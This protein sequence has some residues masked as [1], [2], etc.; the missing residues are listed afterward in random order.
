MF[1][2]RTDVLV[3]LAGEH[4][5]R[6][7]VD[8]ASNSAKSAECRLLMYLQ[9]YGSESWLRQYSLVRHPLMFTDN[10]NMSVLRLV[11]H[12]VRLED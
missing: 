5:Y 6:S 3:S 1:L 10:H 8:A 11:F 2:H 9:V 4:A 7:D 12:S